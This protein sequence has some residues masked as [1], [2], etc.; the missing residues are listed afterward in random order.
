M[1]RARWLWRLTYVSLLILF[2]MLTLAT[3]ALSAA[4]GLPPSFGKLCGHVSGASWKFEGQSGT[5]YGVLARP[6]AS[7][8]VALRSVSG[9]SS[10]KPHAG[11]LGPQTL[12][13]PSGFSC[14]SSGI[15]L[16]HAG[17]CGSKNARFIWAPALEK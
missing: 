15:Q 1:M 16:A 13:G 14:A 8:A 3:T 5:R 6:T 17:F 7:C 11:K 10:Q 9:L 2:A 12:T 4:G